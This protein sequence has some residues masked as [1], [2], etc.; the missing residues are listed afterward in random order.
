MMHDPVRVFTEDV[1]EVP[2]K[3]SG[4]TETEGYERAHNDFKRASSLA[5]T[6]A[7]KAA[8]IASQQT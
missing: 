3:A 5:A 2:R 1:R 6:R 8:V 7:H 4:E